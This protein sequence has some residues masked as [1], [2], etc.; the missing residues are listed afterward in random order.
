MSTATVHVDITPAMMA[1][2]FWGM[3]SGQQ[4]QFFAELARVV[5]ADHE[6][7]NRHAYSLGELQWFFTGASLLEDENREARDMLMTIA[8][9]LYLH[10][11]RATG[12]L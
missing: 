7:G 2:A 8:A 1:E 11:L 3:E 4:V 9:P 5:R 6:A 12:G 10:T